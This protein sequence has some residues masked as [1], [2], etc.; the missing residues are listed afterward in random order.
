MGC[1]CGGRSPRGGGHRAS[2]WQ[3]VAKHTS[4][5][6]GGWTAGG[7]P[8]TSPG[9]SAWLPRAMAALDR[10]HATSSSIGALAESA[11]LPTCMVTAH[12]EPF[13]SPALA[14]RPGL[15]NFQPVHKGERLSAPGTP[16]LTAPFDGHLLFPKYP[17]RLDNGDYAQPLPREIVRVVAPLAAEP[18]VV[19]GRNQPGASP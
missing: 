11:P 6:Q 4:V 10:I 17:R 8:L 16:E 7:R 15:S 12:A 3:R 13:S 19:Y 9:W 14:L 5:I 18:A 1:G 2:V